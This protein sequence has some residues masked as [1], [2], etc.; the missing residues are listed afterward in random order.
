MDCEKMEEA[1]SDFV[2]GCLDRKNHATFSSHISGCQDCRMQLDDFLK[3]R[4]SIQFHKA[5]NPAPIADEHFAGS[6]LASIN[7]SE[8]FSYEQPKI[9]F[10][11]MIQSALAPFRIQ[12][13]APAFAVMVLLLLPVFMLETA[14]LDG[15]MKNSMV[16]SVAEN[17][18]PKPVEEKKTITELDEYLMYHSQNASEPHIVYPVANVSY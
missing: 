17:E 5:V 12:Y 6:V 13:A 2:D 15:V 1:I 4:A 8:A 3:L 14:S 18:V 7:N 10:I 11:E 16:L 9:S